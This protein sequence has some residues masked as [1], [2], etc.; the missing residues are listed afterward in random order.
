MPLPK[1]MIVEDEATVARDIQ[2]ILNNLGYDACCTAAS[3]QEALAKAEEHHPDLVL[4]DIV[5]RGDL[6]GIQ[7]AELL[8]DRF[9][10]PSIFVTAYSDEARIAE[11]KRSE[12]LGYILKPIDEKQL[13][14]TLVLAFHKHML[15]LEKKEAAEQALQES[16]ERYRQL[17]ENVN[18][19]IVMQDREGI[20]TYANDKFYELIGHK[21]DEVLGRS[22]AQFFGEG[23]L[24]PV[25]DG[26]RPGEKSNWKT[27]EM[28]WK[29]KDGGRIFTIISSN[30]IFDEDG[31]LTG[32]VLVLTDISERRAVEL[33]LSRSQEKLRSLSH[34]IQS[35]RE[36]ESKRI[37]REKM[38]SLLS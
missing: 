11:A 6:N 35:A 32:T 26:H 28:S 13:L 31:N 21:R 24:R 19:G 2:Y 34:H 27:Y 17:G 9:D 8:R 36:E 7:T 10:I 25:G 5:L 38:F 22:S 4:M 20:I 23:L 33:E 3:G 16:K 14:I 30:P 29:K 1:I 12:P 15:D 18:E 37:A